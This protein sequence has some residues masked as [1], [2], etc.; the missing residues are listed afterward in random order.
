M[1]GDSGSLTRSAGKRASWA[2]ASNVGSVAGTDQDSVAGGGG[3]TGNANLFD[4]FPPV[5]L[6][7]SSFFKQE[8]DKLKDED[9]YKFLQDLARPAPVFKR[10]K[11]IRYLN[12]KVNFKGHSS[13]RTIPVLKSAHRP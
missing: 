8:A 10:L 1:A 6:T 12:Q 4:S 2:A 9:L 7:V 3:M 13:F 11:V 5:T